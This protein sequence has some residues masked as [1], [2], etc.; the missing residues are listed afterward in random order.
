VNRLFGSSRTICLFSLFII[1]LL[2]ICSIPPL[3]ASAQYSRQFQMNCATCHS[4]PPLLNLFGT[5]FRE[6]YS[7]PNWESNTTLNTGDEETAV[8]KVFPFSIR[9]QLLSRL[10]RDNYVDNLNTGNV[11]KNANFDLQTPN[12]VKLIS[13]TPLTEHIAFHFD[14]LFI[15]G[16][17]SGSFKLNESWLRYRWEDFLIA[18][19]II[20]QFHSSDIIIDRDTRLTLQDYLIYHQTGMQLDRGIR[21]DIIYY[22]FLVSLGIS[23]GS[24]TTTSEV[25]NSAGIGRTD[26]IFDNN[27]RKTLYGYFAK[28]FG[29]YRIG[30]LG[31]INQQYGAAGDFA[32]LYSERLSYQ[33]IAGFDIQAFPSEKVSWIFQFIWNQWKNFLAVGE[34]HQWFGGFLGAHYAYSDTVSYSLLVNYTDA[35]DF[36][37]S[38]TIYEGLA[39]N[40]TT[41]SISYYFR[42]NVR[43][44]LEISMDM[45]PLENDADFIGHESKEDSI[46][47]GFDVNY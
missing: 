47:V 16:D 35:G 9:S 11:G 39:T 2:W 44:V 18:S 8:P 29:A 17:N 38:G 13:S 1:S 33:Y 24:D 40:L 23:N 45:L 3:L 21:A 36:K 12:Y 41:A 20:G 25:A 26:R 27:N 19:L 32:E 28:Q 42:R 31:G 10:R 6:T 14:A 46:S 5:K 30:G 37:N 15:P 43:G 34:K 7:L 4:S 22:D